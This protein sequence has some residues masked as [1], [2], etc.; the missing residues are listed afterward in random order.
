MPQ[1]NRTSPFLSLIGVRAKTA[2]VPDQ[3]LEQGPAGERMF[4][5][6]FS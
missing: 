6:G 5:L 2:A 3:S 1:E 4:S